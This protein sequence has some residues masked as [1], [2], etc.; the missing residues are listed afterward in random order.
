MARS[1]RVLRIRVL[2]I[3][4]LRIRVLRIALHGVLQV[5]DSRDPGG[6]EMQGNIA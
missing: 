1:V 2:R 5:G 3:R 6:G 4:V